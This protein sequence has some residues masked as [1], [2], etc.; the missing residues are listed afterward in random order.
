MAN[1][2]L[3]IMSNERSAI[4]TILW[5]IKLIIGNKAKSITCF[6]STKYFFLIQNYFDLKTNYNFV[7]NIP[8]PTF[9]LYYIPALN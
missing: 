2:G 7:S 8:L 6:T 4:A 1:E 3:L 9:F 5:V